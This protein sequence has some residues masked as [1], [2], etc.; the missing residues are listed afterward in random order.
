MDDGAD[1]RS[2][3]PARP[4]ATDLAG[5]SVAGGPGGQSSR[6]RMK[7]PRTRLRFPLNAMLALCVFAL[8]AFAQ[9]V[10]L[11]QYRRQLDELRSGIDELPDHP[12]RAA[13]LESGLPE[14]ES[15]D[16]GGRE[17]VVSWR[18]LKGDLALIRVADPARRN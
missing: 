17:I 10:S 8:P 12:E 18:E 2:G 16:V 15:I 5:T 13:S 11:E 3:R 7:R 1:G 6:S 4:A 14:K 9:T